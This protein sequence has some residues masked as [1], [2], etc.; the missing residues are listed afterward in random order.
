MLLNWTGTRVLEVLDKC[1]DSFTFQMLD[2][3]YVYLA[4]TRMSLHRSTRDW[5]LVIEVFGFSP[6]SGLPDTHIYTFSSSLYARKPASDFVSA[7]AYQRYVSNNPNNESSFVYPIDEGDWID[8][9]Q[10]ELIAT[11][12]HEVTLR[13]HKRSM[14]HLNDYAAAGVI[15]SEAPRATVFEFCRALAHVAR[16]EVL[17]TPEERVARLNP[18]MRQIL[19]LDEWNHPD[20]VDDSKRPSNSETFQQLVE[21]LITGDVQKYRPMLSPNTHWKHWP[22]GGSL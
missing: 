13:G 8:S 19:Q 2:N 4:A 22:D 1:C 12:Q 18:G 3:G 16:E 11:G 21:V 14:P 9:E 7:D 15:P 6:R 10:S 20:V 5:G 17:A